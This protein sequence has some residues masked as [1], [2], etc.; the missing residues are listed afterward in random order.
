MK[1]IDLK[2]DI[3]LLGTL[4]SSWAANSA[5]LKEVA[6]NMVEEMR[7]MTPDSK[8]RELKAEEFKKIAEESKAFE[9]MSNMAGSYLDKLLVELIKESRFKYEHLGQVP[10]KKEDRKLEVKK[11]VGNEG[12]RMEEM[13]D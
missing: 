8:D 9:L 1:K 7:K 4:S 3:V 12:S 6:G 10:K 11:P 5:Q 2:T 13:K